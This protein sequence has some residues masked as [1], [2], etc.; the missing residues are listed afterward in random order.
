M[1]QSKKP[2]TTA[3]QSHLTGKD[4]VCKDLASK[5]TIAYFRAVMTPQSKEGKF[6]ISD[7]VMDSTTTKQL[8]QHDIM[9]AKSISG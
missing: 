1:A 4:F 3:E 8:R 7:E 2:F 5:Q 6:E 9:N